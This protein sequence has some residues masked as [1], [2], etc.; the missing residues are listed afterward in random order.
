MTTTVYWLTFN[1]KESIVI[2]R[3]KRLIKT[4]V[5]VHKGILCI[6]ILYTNTHRSKITRL[7]CL[8]GTPEFHLLDHVVS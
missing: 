3:Q 7:L 5:S 1:V 4:Q 6:Y 8:L 2:I